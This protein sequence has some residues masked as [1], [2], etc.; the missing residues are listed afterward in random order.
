MH[1]ITKLL[2]ELG[3]GGGGGGGGGEEIGDHSIGL[4]SSLKRVLQAG[5]CQQQRRL[6][7]EKI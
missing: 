6:L 4:H 2:H 3:R 5:V 1:V 7:L